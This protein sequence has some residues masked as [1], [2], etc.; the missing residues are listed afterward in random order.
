[1]ISRIGT[2][3]VLPREHHYKF[4]HQYEGTALIPG[5]KSFLSEPVNKF[6]LVGWQYKYGANYQARIVKQR[7][8]LEAFL[9]TTV[10]NESAGHLT[11]ELE[12]LFRRLPQFI[13]T[14]VDTKRDNVS[15]QLDNEYDLQ[16]IV[17]AI[18]RLHYADVRR[19][20]HVPSRSGANSRVDFYLRE[21]GVMVEVKMTRNGLADRRANYWH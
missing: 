4:Q 8:M 6:P 15:V 14:L 11:N 12:R 17:E 21:S 13:R 7:Q 16:P 2:L 20:E 1:M 18:L 9:V 3:H 10:S 19:E 5:I